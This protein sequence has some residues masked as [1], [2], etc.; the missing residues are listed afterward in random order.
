MTCPTLHT[1]VTIFK[2][3]SCAATVHVAAHP[4]HQC[5]CGALE[6]VWWLVL[7]AVLTGLGPG[8]V[9]PDSTTT[10]GGEPCVRTTTGRGVGTGGGAWCREARVGALLVLV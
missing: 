7:G 5:V 2:S 6:W 1:C 10:D 4:H 3:V 8:T 9:S